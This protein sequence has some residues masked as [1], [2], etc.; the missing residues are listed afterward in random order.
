MTNTE[1]ASIE[2]IEL[3]H[4]LSGEGGKIESGESFSL[5]VE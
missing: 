2:I 5:T 3:E 1:N 4:P